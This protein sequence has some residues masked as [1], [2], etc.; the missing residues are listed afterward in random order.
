MAIYSKIFTKNL[1]K[2]SFHNKSL[3]LSKSCQLIT[4]KIVKNITPTLNF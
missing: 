1:G 2:K 3:I 4:D